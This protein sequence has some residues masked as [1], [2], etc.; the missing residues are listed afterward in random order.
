M[1]SFLPGFIGRKRVIGTVI[2]VCASLFLLN[3]YLEG[4]ISSLLG[5]SESSK[6]FDEFQVCQRAPVAPIIATN[7]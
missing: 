5:D 3:H 2:A 7:T 6:P 1:Q 4:G